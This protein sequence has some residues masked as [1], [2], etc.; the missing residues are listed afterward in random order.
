MTTV[1]SEVLIHA[2]VQEVFAFASDWSCWA[3]WFAGTSDFRP[4]TAQTR[5]T[6]ARYAYRARVLGVRVPVETEICDFVEDGGWT[7]VGRGG[8]ESRTHWSFVPEGD[9]TRF[10]FRMEYRIP[11]MP[12]V[13]DRLLVRPV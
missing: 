6:G 5:G 3:D 13:L 10:T 1:S 9:D 8:P 11:L 7:G 4:L 2:P 12:D